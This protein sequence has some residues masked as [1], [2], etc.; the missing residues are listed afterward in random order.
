M[1]PVRLALVALP[2]VAACAGKKAEPEPSP[3]ARAA[4]DLVRSQK[5][6][7]ALAS[8]SPAMRPAGGIMKLGFSPEA[9]RA[10]EAGSA[11]VAF[12]VLPN[13]RVDRDSRTLLYIEGHKVFA[14]YVCDALLSARFEPPPQDARGG[15]STYPVFFYIRE[16]DPR[17]TARA[18][19]TAASILIS[20][21]LATMTFD[22]SLTWFQA[23]PP[24][25]AI[26]IGVEPLY[27]PPPQ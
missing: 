25:T 2:F 17:D 1:K 9:L 10:G 22:E 4:A 3:A 24:C 13:G 23:R 5:L 15:V 11:V 18:R 6:A 14:K 7:Q 12:V 8:R 21:K 20:R 19:L 26:K 16:G 27:G